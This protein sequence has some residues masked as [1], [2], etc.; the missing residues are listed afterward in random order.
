MNSDKSSSTMA[1]AS[2]AFGI[3]SI[4][5]SC[6]GTSLIFGSIGL[7][8][9]LLSRGGSNAYPKNTVAG[10]ILNAIGIFIGAM[11]ILIS[12]ITIAS[13]GSIDN[14]MNAAEKYLGHYYSTLGSM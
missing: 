10:L 1:F 9:A 14:F 7:I 6:F 2:V 5:A 13:F 12:I 11:M 3:I 4:I 8:L